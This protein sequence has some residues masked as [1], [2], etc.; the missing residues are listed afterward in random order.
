MLKLKISLIKGIKTNMSDKKPVYNKC[1]NCGRYIETDVKNKSLFCSNECY[2]NYSCCSICNQ[3]YNAEKAHD[4]SLKCKIIFDINQ[5]KKPYIKHTLFKLLIFGSP[6][7]GIEMVSGNLSNVLKLP[8]FISEKFRIENQFT[9]SQIKN[10]IK[11][12]IEAENLQN[13]F[14]FLCNSYNIE[15]ISELFSELS[16]DIVI[17]IDSGKIANN[18]LKIQICSNCGNINCFFKPDADSS[19]CIICGNNYYRDSEEDIAT[20]NK[21]KNYQECKS[22]VSSM[23]TVYKYINF[24]TVPETVNEIVKYL[25]YS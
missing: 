20:I 2:E 7:V 22:F 1:V 25:V 19:E 10:H 16:F 23:A 24:T 12:K 5:K 21:I 14:I 4:E 17:A 9:L 13:Y 3:Y 11:H 15:F 18:N 6:L 8:L